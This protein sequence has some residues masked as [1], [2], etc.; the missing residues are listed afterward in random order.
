MRSQQL[1]IDGRDLPP[2]V[3]AEARSDGTGAP[4]RHA[5]WLQHRLR[6]VRRRLGRVGFL[7]GLDRH[8]TV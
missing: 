3:A 8:R 4:V 7:L 6:R 1:A 5:T 2:K